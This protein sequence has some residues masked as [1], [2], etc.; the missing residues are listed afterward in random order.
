MIKLGLLGTNISHSKSQEMYERI[1]GESVDYSLLDYP[2][3]V[4]IPSLKEL[5]SQDFLGLSITYPFKQTFL[6][7]V[8]IQDENVLSLNAINCIRQREGRFEATN[9]DFLAAQELIK[10]F[11]PKKYEILIL[12]SGNMARVFEL[13]LKKSTYSWKQ[14]SRSSD[15][16]LNQFNYV[17]H[18]KEIAD[19]K[20]LLLI[21]CCSR[22]FIFRGELPEGTIFWDMNYAFPEHENLSARGIEYLSGLDLLF[23][24]AKFAADYWGIKPL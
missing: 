23:W 9:T 3:E 22:D 6:N 11:S 18:S 4:E 19:N 13:C 16:D 21:N 24:Q 15:G 14:I 20:N 12:G 2:N 8:L 7:D 17:Q 10:K 5:F 1:L